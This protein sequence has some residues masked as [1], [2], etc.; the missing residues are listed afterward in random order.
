MSAPSVPSAVEV[1]EALHGALV[2]VTG[3][4]GG[5][6]YYRHADGF[7]WSCTREGAPAPSEPAGRDLPRAS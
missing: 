6:R 7:R 4:E 3:P 1:A 2:D 5:P